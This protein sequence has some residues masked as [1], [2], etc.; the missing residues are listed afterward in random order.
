MLKAG[1]RFTVTSEMVAIEPLENRMCAVV[2]PVGETIRLVRYPCQSDDRMADV[3]WGKRPIVV[4]GRDLQLRANEIKAMP[5]ARAAG[6][7]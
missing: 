3:L 6:R 2:V 4:F 5:A 1:Q 7:N